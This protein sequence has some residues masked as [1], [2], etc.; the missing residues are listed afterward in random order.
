MTKV[1]KRFSALNPHKRQGGFTLI[2]LLVVIAIIAVLAAVVLV[3]LGNARTRARDARRVSDLNN[4]ALAL[5]VYLDTMNVA[6]Y[7]TAGVAT[8][9]N[10][11]WN[12]LVTSLR[13]ANVIQGTI[14]DPLNIA[15]NLYRAQSNL[16]NANGT[17]A[18]VNTTYL[19]GADLE[20]VSTASCASDYDGPNLG[21]V[22]VGPTDCAEN[23]AS[24]CNGDDT[25]ELD[26]CVC[27]GPAC[28]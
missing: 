12:T 25:Q 28:E 24:D 16:A 8:P 7:P 19:L 26:Y 13:G 4:V 11:Q 1:L 18:A 3:A 6:T 20:T 15:E 2:E 22:A 21:T 27:S 5:E 23:V 14:Q 10:A 9:D 17:G